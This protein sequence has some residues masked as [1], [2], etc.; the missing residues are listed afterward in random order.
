MELLG[1]K[2]LSFL[3]SVNT[4]RWNSGSQAPHSAEKFVSRIPRIKQH[5]S[6]G[7][8]RCSVNLCNGLAILSCQGQRPSGPRVPETCVQ[9]VSPRQ[10]WVSN[11]LQNQ[12]H[13]LMYLSH[14]LLRKVNEVHKH[15][16][17][18]LGPSFVYIICIW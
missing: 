4:T 1:L 7:Y 8:V 10:V 11:L 17:A 16:F 14:S 13:Q 5:D 9:D 18:S 2:M 15:L 6:E 12:G 3:S